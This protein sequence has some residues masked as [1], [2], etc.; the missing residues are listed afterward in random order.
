MKRAPSI[1]TEPTR[2]DSLL[3]VMEQTSRTDLLVQPLCSFNA[4][5]C[6]KE[7]RTASLAV[8]HV[9]Y[10]SRL[11]KTRVVASEEAVVFVR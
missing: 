9:G 11:L 3:R 1:G 7:A 8:F 10:A 5:C 6:S 2:L 4:L